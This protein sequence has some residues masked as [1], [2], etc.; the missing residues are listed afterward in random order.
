MRY[1]EEEEAGEI[2]NQPVV[3]RRFRPDQLLDVVLS[4]AGEEAKRIRLSRRSLPAGA[5]A[6]IPRAFYRRNID[7]CAGDGTILSDRVRDR[8]SRMG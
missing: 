7:H 3:R 8:L 2:T 1:R 4:V 5:H 6:G